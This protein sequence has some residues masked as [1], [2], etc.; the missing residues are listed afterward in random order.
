MR[1]STWNKERFREIL[2]QIS[3]ETGLDQAE[4]ATLAERS[5]STFSRWTRAEVQPTVQAVSKFALAVR[6]GYPQLGDL[7]EELTAAAGYGAIAGINVKVAAEHIEERERSA[8]AS[9]RERAAATGKTLGDILL[10]RGLATPQE[11]TVSDERLDD[12]IVRDIEKLDIPDETK[13]ALIETYASERRKMF[14]DEGLT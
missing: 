4:L 10:E 1:T 3:N 12:P 5:P 11:L 13:N 8:L 14:R 6:L 9:L 2:R 7:A